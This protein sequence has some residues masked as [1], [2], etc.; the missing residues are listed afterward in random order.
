MT[1]YTTGTV[2]VTNSDATVTGV[3]TAFTSEV[4]AGD[5]FTVLDSGVVYEV[6]VVTDDTNIEL[7][8]AYAGTT[9]AGESYVISRDFTP[10]YDIPYI[11]KTDIEK[12]SILKRMTFKLEELLSA[13]QNIANGTFTPVLTDGSNNVSTYFY[14][15][16]R[17]TKI[18]DRVFVEIHMSVNDKGSIT[19]DLKITG[20]PYTSAN[21]TGLESA[22]PAFANLNGYSPSAGDNFV[23]F[24][25]SN[26]TEVTILTSG[27]NATPVDLQGANV[28][29]GTQIHIT[30]S[31]RTTA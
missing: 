27:I 16:G 6:G 14:R 13:R 7:T 30:G 23:A 17:Y 26:T 21:E 29:G 11:N 19:G 4:T 15:V 9:A 3:G 5:L 2:T 22:L 24:V 25:P 12:A 18:D 20:L 10:T 8:A 31:Y 28:T 1:Q